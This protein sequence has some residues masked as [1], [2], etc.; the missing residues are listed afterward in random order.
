MLPHKNVHLKMPADLTAQM[1][2]I[3]TKEGKTPVQE[4]RHEQRNRD[5]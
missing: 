5:R 4:T 1:E 2:A 3:A